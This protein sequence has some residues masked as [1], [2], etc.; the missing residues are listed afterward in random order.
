MQIISWYR[1]LQ[2][3]KDAMNLFDSVRTKYVFMYLWR[4]IV[5]MNVDP[6][7]YNKYILSIAIN[8]SIYWFYIITQCYPWTKGRFQAFRLVKLRSNWTALLYNI[9][10][11]LRNYLHNF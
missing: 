7:I 6:E 4:T 11:D 1:L 3:W 10:Y 8:F 5:A 9:A 2:G